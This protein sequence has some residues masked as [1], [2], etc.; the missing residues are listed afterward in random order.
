MGRERLTRAEIL[1]QIPAARERGRRLDETEPLA[2]EARYDA[3]SGRVVVELNDGAQFAFRAESEPELRGASQE[4]LAKVRVTPAGTALHWDE[5]DAG[6]L[7][8]PLLR[9]LFRLA[10]DPAAP[11]APQIL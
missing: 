10:A 5:L 8:A 7:V 3:K 4:A 9:H 2:V 1:A 11:P 6:L